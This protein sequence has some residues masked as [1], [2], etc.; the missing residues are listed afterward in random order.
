MDCPAQVEI[1]ELLI[2]AVMETLEQVELQIKRRINVTT[3]DFTLVI[4]NVEE[5]GRKKPWDLI[6]QTASFLNL[7][8]Y[9][10]CVDELTRQQAD[11]NQLRD[12]QL[13][14]THF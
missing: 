4:N 13:L 1:R 10:T 3:A 14:W 8:R 5:E 9:V 11:C 12:K 6:K 2:C 7:V